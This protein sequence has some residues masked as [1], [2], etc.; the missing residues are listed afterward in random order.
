MSR[1]TARDPVSSVPSASFYLVAGILTSIY[2]IGIHAVRLRILPDVSCR[3]C[4]EE[5][6]EKTVY[7]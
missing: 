3:N 7:I 1:S 5:D 4:M 2:L 6:E